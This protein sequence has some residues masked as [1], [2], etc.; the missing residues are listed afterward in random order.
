LVEKEYI[1]AAMPHNAVTRV[2]F[3]RMVFEQNVHIIV[4]LNDEHEQSCQAYWPV[5]VPRLLATCLS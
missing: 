4:M 3:W 1:A 5:K 2:D